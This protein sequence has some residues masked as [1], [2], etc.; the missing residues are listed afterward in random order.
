MKKEKIIKL[1]KKAYQQGVWDALHQKKN[2]ERHD[3]EISDDVIINLIEGEE[4][5]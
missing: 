5:E 3:I 4:H 1:L 2:S